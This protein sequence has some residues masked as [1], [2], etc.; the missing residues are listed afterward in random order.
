MRDQLESGELKRHFGIWQ[1]TALNVAMVVGAGVFIAIPQMLKVAPGPYALLGWLLAGALILVDGLFWSELGPPCPGRAGSYHYLLESY[2]RATWGRLAAFLFI[3]QFL[4]SGPLELASGLIAMDT[5]S[6]SLS[7]TW[8]NSTR[9]PGCKSTCGNRRKTG[10]QTRP[11]PDH[12]P[13]RRDPHHHPAL[14]PGDDSRAAHPGVLRGRAGA[15]RLDHHRGRGTLQMVGGL[16]LPHSRQTNRCR[17][18]HEA[19]AVFLPGVLQHL[20][21]G[22]RGA[23][24]GQ[25]DPARG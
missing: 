18:G 2:G 5:F 11:G 22:R 17:C 3:W 21:P 13:R 14:Q 8:K 9:L 25:D 7:P 12:G 15:H 19:G 24:P 10:S 16:C 6:Q 23:Q 20:L 4:L 1:A